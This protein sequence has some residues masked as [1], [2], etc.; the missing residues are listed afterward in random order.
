MEKFYIL[1]H[2]EDCDFGVTGYFNNEYTL[3]EMEIRTIEAD[4]PED[5]LRVL[6]SKEYSFDCDNEQASKIFTEEEFNNMKE[7][8]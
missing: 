6:R 3:D 4:T 8:K 7:G 1:S 5:L 2:D